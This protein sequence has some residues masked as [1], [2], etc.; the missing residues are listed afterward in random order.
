MYMYIVMHFSDDFLQIDK[1]CFDTVEVRIAQCS[2]VTASGMSGSGECDTG[3]VL[4]PLLN[5][6]RVSVVVESGL[7]EGTHYTATLSF[8]SQDITSTNFCEYSCGL[9]CLNWYKSV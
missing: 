3:H 2:E 6:E 4:V 7:E 5:E 9:P 8:D 1:F